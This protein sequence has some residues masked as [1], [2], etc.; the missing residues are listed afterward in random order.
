MSRVFIEAMELRAI[1]SDS[2]QW[3]LMKRTK[4]DQ[5]GYSEWVSYSYVSSFGMAAS[6]LEEE[7]IRD[8]GAQTFTEL[9]RLAKQIHDQLAEIFKKA[10]GYREH[11]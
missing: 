6:N 8:C 3:M 1:S 4:K 9:S 10:E 2:R 11:D 5:G 7:L